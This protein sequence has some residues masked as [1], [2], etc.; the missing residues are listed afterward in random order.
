MWQKLRLL[1]SR[2]APM[3]L[4]ENR[5]NLKEGRLEK[6]KSTQHAYDMGDRVNWDETRI[7]E[8]ESSSFYR[9]YKESAHMACISNPI[10]QP[11][12]DISPN[13]IS[14]ISNEITNSQRSVWCGRFF[15]DFY[16]F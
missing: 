9:K 4:R 5:H 12:L 14:F 16:R 6:L 1:N 15:I 13:W 8:I 7:L 3:R 2:S 11:S 10:T